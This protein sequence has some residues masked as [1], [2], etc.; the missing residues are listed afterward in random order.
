MRSSSIVEPEVP[1]EPL[2]KEASG[3][4]EVETVEADDEVNGEENGEI[5]GK[6]NEEESG[7]EEEYTDE[8]SVL[9]TSTLSSTDFFSV[10]E[11]LFTD[12][13]Y[14]VTLSTTHIRR[15]PCPQPR[16]ARGATDPRPRARTM[17]FPPT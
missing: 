1:L 10:H 8:A 17:T 9:R 7:A 11:M 5:N 15:H 14:K 13:L 3:L 2:R 12:V 16:T 4:Q 6:E